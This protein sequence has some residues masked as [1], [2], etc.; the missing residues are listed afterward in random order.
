MRTICVFDAVGAV[1][2]H[3]HGF[4]EAL[5]FV[6][7]AAHAD[8]IDV[9]PVALALRMLL[10]IAVD[11]AGAGEEEARILQ[12]RQAQRVVRAE[13]AD[14]ER[15][16]RIVAD[17][18]RGWPATRSAARCRWGRRSR[19]GCEMSWRMNVKRSLLAQMLDVRQR[20]GDEVVDAD[21]L[22][23]AFEKALAQVRA[24]EARAPGD[25]RSHA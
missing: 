7:A 3:G 8:R 18:R 25:D 1:I 19:C 4:G 12:L 16:N 22:V 15:L 2:G 23:A 6:V 10:R 21:D 9:A 11:F 14:L 17:N 24:D 20:A 13:R 5:G